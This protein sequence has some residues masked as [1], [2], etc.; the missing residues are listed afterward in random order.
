MNRKSSALI[1]LTLLVA[2]CGDGG[3]ERDELI[4]RIEALEKQVSKLTA[5]QV[6]EL[7]TN[8][9]PFTERQVFATGFVL[10]DH[11]GERRAALNFGAPHSHD[12]HGPG[13]RIYDSRNRLKLLLLT[14]TT[15]DRTQF[16]LFDNEG[17]SIVSAMANGPPGVGG[18]IVQGIRSR[19]PVIESDY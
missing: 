19:T 14:E 3:G 16:V 2:G 12:Q 7:T 1:G 18:V 11:A 4:K 17:G 6:F 15:T 10:V 13:L 5:N 9:H 8:G